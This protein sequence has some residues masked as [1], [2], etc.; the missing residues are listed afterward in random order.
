MATVAARPNRL[1]RFRGLSAFF[2]TEL[3]V[4]L[5]EGLA[6]LT[7]MIVQG[8]LL[9]FV[10]ILAPGYLGVALVGALLFSVFQMGQR[11]QNEAAYVRIDHKLNELYL[12]SPLTAEA[13]FLGMAGGVL[14]AYLSPILVLVGITELV[15][16]PSPLTWLV[17]VAAAAALWFITISIGYTIS[18]LFR[19]MRTIWPY[20]SLFY[21]LFG[22]LPPVF[23]PLVLFPASLRTVALLIPPSAAAALI[24]QARV[25]GIL[26]GSEILLA[27]C[28]LTVEAVAMFVFAVA[29]ARREV[30]QV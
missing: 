16:H 10:T 23:Y 17:L 7:S 5:H 1:F 6:I 20:A 19:D 8:V 14:V 25:G 13:Y 24:N 2:A 12:A 15:I 18:T 22:V 29:W 30:R 11:V 26:T 21:N 28:A 3:R 27:A 9:V 4:Q